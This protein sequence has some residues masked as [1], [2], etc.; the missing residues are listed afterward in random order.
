MYISLITASLNELDTPVKAHRLLNGCNNK[1]YIYIYIYIVYTY[2][3]THYIYYIYSIPYIYLYTIYTLYKRPTSVPGTHTESRVMEKIFHA[4]GN[5]KTVG[6]AILIS[7]KIDFK[8][9]TV[10]RD[11]GHHIM[12][13]GSI[14]KDVTIV[15]MYAPHIGARQYIRPMLTSI[16]GE[17]NSNI[18]RL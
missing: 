16:K 8:M 2:I 7:H 15:N 6:V 10:I 3:Y 18:G 17:L 11:K 13:K 12:I 9:K 4:N 5:Q 1:T 14:Q